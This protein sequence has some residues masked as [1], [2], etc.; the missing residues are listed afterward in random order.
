MGSGSLVGSG[1]LLSARLSTHTDNRMDA[2][3]ATESLYLRADEIKLGDILPDVSRTPVVAIGRTPDDA[4]HPVVLTFANMFTRAARYGGA[5]YGYE[6]FRVERAVRMPVNPDTGL[7]NVTYG[8]C[9]AARVRQLTLDIT[10]VRQD[11]TLTTRGQEFVASERRARFANNGTP[12]ATEYARAFESE[13][14]YVRACDAQHAANP[15]RFEGE[16]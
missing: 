2:I 14:D 10:L 15:H 6:C 7:Y 5:E 1:L 8:E 13:E 3:M 16:L 4:G 11:G 12:S 9:E